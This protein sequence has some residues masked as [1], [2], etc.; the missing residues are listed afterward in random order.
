[1]WFLFLISGP[2]A[3]CLCH[4]L[5]GQWN[6]TQLVLQ[7][8]VKDLCDGCKDQEVLCGPHVGHTSRARFKVKPVGAVAALCSQGYDMIFGLSNT[9]L[10]L[11]A[12]STNPMTIHLHHPMFAHNG[13]PELPYPFGPHATSMEETHNT[14]ESEDKLTTSKNSDYKYFEGTTPSGFKVV[15]NKKVR[16][17]PKAVSWRDMLMTYNHNQETEPG[18]NFWSRVDENHVIAD[19]DDEDEMPSPCKR[20]RDDDSSVDSAEDQEMPDLLNPEDS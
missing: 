7:G 9:Q 16:V 6:C 11:H 2:N 1:M 17:I 14:Y 18:L 15:G 20:T 13:I 4:H 8:N 10:V 19:L 3:K 12:H 5:P